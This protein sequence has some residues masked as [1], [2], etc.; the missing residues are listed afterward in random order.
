[1]RL[2][3]DDVMGIV[4]ASPGCTVLSYSVPSFGIDDDGEAIETN[5]YVLA[6][7]GRMV[8]EM[9]EFGSANAVDLPV[10][11]WAVNERRSSRTPV[12]WVCD[13]Y[14]T[15]YGDVGHETLTLQAVEYCL[16]HSIAIVP[17]A[18]SAVKYLT[19]LGMGARP[20]KSFP[21]VMKRAYEIAT[22]DRLV[23]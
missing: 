9:P 21:H 12:V 7:C 11:K 22:G 17:D 10:L 3:R 23:A 2:D 19:E 8:D 18:E 15:G 13:G 4:K 6:S 20:T 16:A 1:M 5:A 14:V